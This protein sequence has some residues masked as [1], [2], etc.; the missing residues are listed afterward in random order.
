MWQINFNIGRLL[1]I[2]CS[3]TLI[4]SSDVLNLILDIVGGRGAVNPEGLQFY[5]NLI[6]ELMKAGLF[7]LLNFILFEYFSC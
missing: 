1:M 3:S 2:D 4:T 7:F 5:N 6:D